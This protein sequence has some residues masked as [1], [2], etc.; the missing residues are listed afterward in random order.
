MGK[1]VDSRTS[2]DSGRMES[3]FT[4]R[5]VRLPE[6]VT[7]DAKIE[8][9]DA[10][11]HLKD[12]LNERPISVKEEVFYPGG[13][14]PMHYHL[15][16]WQV[17]IGVE[18]ELVISTPS[19]KTCLR[20]DTVVFIAPG[21]IH[22]AENT[23][24][25]F[26]RFLIVSSPDTKFDREIMEPESSVVDHVAY[27]RS[28]TNRVGDRDPVQVLA[29]TPQSIRQ[30]I[31]DVQQSVL[32]MRPFAE[33]WTPREIIMHFVD[34]ALNR[35][36][37]FRMILS[38]RHPVLTGYDERELVSIRSE[39]RAT[40]FEDIELFSSIQR[41]DVALLEQSKHRFDL[42]SHHLERGETTLGELVHLEAGHDLHHLDQLR[43]YIAAAREMR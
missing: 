3:R 2:F 4:F 17:F 20:K 36:L 21:T 27:S 28:L 23:T 14:E 40:A 16:C 18:G 25:E 42:P 10:H 5:G 24:T 11:R 7:F 34:S 1:S 39:Q 9:L 37:R 33:K 32:E 6:G 41:A 38:G 29:E 35:S 13:T 8:S 12:L 31:E 30:A 19:E 15:A 26:A 22:T 43:R